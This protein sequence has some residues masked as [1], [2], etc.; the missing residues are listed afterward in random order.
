M[1]DR[2]R[3]NRPAIYFDE[4]PFF[5]EAST[6][7]ETNPLLLSKTDPGGAHVIERSARNC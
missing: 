5:V 7:T 2:T 6:L 4:L 3:I 1:I